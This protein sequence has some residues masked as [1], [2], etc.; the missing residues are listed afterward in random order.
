ME[1]LKVCSRCKETKSLS[2]FYVDRSTTDE[3]SRICKECAAKQKRAFRQKRRISNS[4][5]D[6]SSLRICKKCLI[7]KPLSE[8]Y[9]NPDYALGRSLTCRTCESQESSNWQK[10]KRLPELLKKDSWFSRYLEIGLKTCCDCGIRKPFSEFLV[11]SRSR[12]RLGNLCPECRSIRFRDNYLKKAKNSGFS[13]ASKARAS[14]YYEREKQTISNKVKSDRVANPEKWHRKDRKQ[15]LQRLGRRRGLDIRSDWGQAHIQYLEKWQNGYCYHCNAPLNGEYH[16]DHIFPLKFNGLHSPVNLVLSCIDCNSHKN[17]KFL[18]TEWNP[19]ISHSAPEESYYVFPGSIMELLGADSGW[20]LNQEGFG[21]LIQ[22]T[23]TRKLYVLSSFMCSD[24][25][26][27]SHKFPV[28]LKKQEPESIIL[29]DYELEERLS[30]VKNMLKAKVGI[31]D[32]TGARTLIPEVIG[33]LEA[34]E[35]LDTYHVMGFQTGTHYIGLKNSDG[36]LYGVGAF[37]FHG[38]YYDNVRLAFRNHV[39]G[40]MSRIFQFLWKEF[41]ELPIRSYVDSRYAD[42]SGHMAIGFTSQG[43]T[44]MGYRWITP[45][46]NYHYRYLSNGRKIRQNLPNYLEKFTEK[47]NILMHGIYKLWVPPLRRIEYLPA[48]IP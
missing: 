30:A 4:S 46:G 24:R 17:S 15:Y 20:Q 5:V 40:G 3:H 33:S 2:A 32:K 35:F 13:I 1:N 29:F 38:D 36:V 25:N 47:E 9:R 34:R 48:T 43:M 26:S 12:D 22:G 27:E 28:R 8:Y 44:S 37:Y 31:S 7:S 45:S 21:I 23:C 14:K 42:G 41:G 39:P 10:A 19:P 11:N 16:I 6:L 18:H